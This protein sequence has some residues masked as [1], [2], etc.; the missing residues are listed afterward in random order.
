MGKK[1]FFSVIRNLSMLLLLLTILFFI[2]LKPSPINDF[3]IPITST[4]EV[5]H[6]TDS[7]T[8]RWIGVN[9]IYL[10][11]IRLRGWRKIDQMGS[12]F[13]FEK[14]GKRVSIIT[15]KDGFQLIKE[16]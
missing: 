5:A 12:L 6:S 9:T 11:V 1:H 13:T 14:A 10:D 7:I 4:I 2:I 8:Y 16:N 15:F 3:P